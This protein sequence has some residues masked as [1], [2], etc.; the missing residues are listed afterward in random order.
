[1]RRCAFLRVTSCLVTALLVT[2][3]GAMAAPPDGTAAPPSLAIRASTQKPGPTVE[4]RNKALAQARL[5]QRLDPTLENERT[6]GEAYADV[7]VLDHALDH[8]QAALRLDPHDVP[9]LDG[10]ARIWR[11]ANV[12][13]PIAY[14]A[15]YWAPDSAA[16]QNTL[17]TLFLKLGL[18]DA[19]RERFET[20]RAL[21]PAAAYP[22]NNLCYLELQR[23]NAPEAV[24]LCREAA[25]VDP[26][27]PTVRNNLAVAL[28]TSGDVEGAFSVFEAGSSPAIAAYNQGIVLL[29]TH[30]PALAR[31]AFS[32]ART[33]DPAFL[34][35]LTRL[36]ALVAVRTER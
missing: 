35:A 1:M 5:R 21:D 6:L 18:R 24:R 34:P 4:T 32:R 28:A 20:A 36:K 16:T 8:F 22:V 15:V 14:R 13:L 19:A 31:D 7:G 25:A 26:G 10:L 29:A 17:G 12:A 33:A 11:Y 27:S 3:R 23:S 2:T 9:S 30:Q